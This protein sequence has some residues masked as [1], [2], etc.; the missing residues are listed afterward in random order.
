M[1]PVQG[2]DLEIGDLL[3][4]DWTYCVVVLISFTVNLQHHISGTVP[5]RVT[6]TTISLILVT[7][8]LLL[9]WTSVAL[10]LSWHDHWHALGYNKRIIPQRRYKLSVYL[11]TFTLSVLIEHH[12]SRE[13]WVSACILSSCGEQGISLFRLQLLYVFMDV[14]FFTF[15]LHLLISQVIWGPT[16]SVI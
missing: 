11:L 9:D 2:A 15:S 7:F 8:Q 16:Q 3:K 12:F 4:A 5:V 10:V 6:M 13:L 14:V 1:V